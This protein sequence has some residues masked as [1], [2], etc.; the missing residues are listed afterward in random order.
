MHSTALSTVP[1]A[2]IMIISV[3]GLIALIALSNSIPLIFD[4]MI[5]DKTKSTRSVDLTC[6]SASTPLSVV[7]TR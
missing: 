2:V 1:K 3:D 4:I 7:V 5:S 6:S